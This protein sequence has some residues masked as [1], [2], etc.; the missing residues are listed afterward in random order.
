MSDN[1]IIVSKTE[2][3]D[4]LAAK[5]IVVLKADLVDLLAEKDSLRYEVE[6]LRLTAAEREAIGV[7]IQ[8]VEAARAQRHPE[9][10]DA[11]DLLWKAICGLRA[12]LARA[13]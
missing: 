5:K 9:E 2:F 11:R 10:E 8:C 7:A 3:A 13:K 4:L 6:R 1:E 12:L